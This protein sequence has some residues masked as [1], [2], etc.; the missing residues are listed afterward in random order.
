MQKML[1]NKPL[2]YSQLLPDNQNSF[3]NLLLFQQK[4]FP[5]ICLNLKQ[6]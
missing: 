3:K 5:I 1:R 2:I 4:S 6:N